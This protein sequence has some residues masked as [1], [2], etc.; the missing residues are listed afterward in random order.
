M[1]Y[2]LFSNGIVC[3]NLSSRERLHDK[4]LALQLTYTWMKQ[5]CRRVVVGHPCILRHCCNHF[6][7]KT[8]IE[9]SD[10]WLQ[11][12]IPF[13]NSFFFQLCMHAISKTL[14]VNYILATKREIVLCFGTGASSASVSI[15]WELTLFVT[16][17]S[18]E[19]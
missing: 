19:S 1:D 18:N 4:P 16:T 3:H 10:K 6:W 8:T 7:N 12:M 17:S 15:V 14:A 13:L 2:I 11:T 9:I 5:Y